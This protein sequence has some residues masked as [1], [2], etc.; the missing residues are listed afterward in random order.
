MQKIVIKKRWNF[1]KFFI[2]LLLVAI[3]AV[4]FS[5]AFFSQQ[6]QHQVVT[7]K[8]IQTQQLTAQGKPLSVA[9][10]SK[11]VTEAPQSKNTISFKSL[12]E[13]AESVYDPKEKNRREGLLWLDRSSSRFIITLGAINGLKLQDSLIVVDGNKRIGEVIVDTTFDVISYVHPTEVTASRL[14]NNYYR[15]FIK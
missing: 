6:P 9:Q 12:L 14:K 13:H 10:P 11:P 4:I 3:A 1:K 2:G 7:Q 5:Y 8:L 15:V